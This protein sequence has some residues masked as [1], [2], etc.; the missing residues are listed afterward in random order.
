MKV[1]FTGGSSFTGFWFVKGLAGA[2]HEVVSVF[3]KGDD[4]YS[5]IRKKRMDYLREMSRT[6]FNC[7]FGSDK[8]LSLIRSENWDLLCQ[9]AADVTNYKSPD[10]DIV[11]AVR[12]NTENLSSVLKMLKEKKCNRVLFTGSVF[13]GNEG[14][15]S[16]NLRAFSPYGLSKGLT[17]EIFKY[18]TTAMD[19]RLGKFVIPNPFGPYEEPRFTSYLIRSWFERKIPQVASPAYVRDNIHIS[20]LATAYVHFA[21]N[22]ADKPGFERINPSGYPESQGA[23]ALRFS[24]E[25]RARLSLPCELELAEQRDFPEP[26]VRIN[27]DIISHLFPAWNEKSAWDEL[28]EFYR[29]E[30]EFK[31][32]N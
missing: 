9:H 21:E 26:R 8:F 14:A 12:N 32:G 15:G 6:V 27:T 5:G 25:M 3:T 23:F 20:L 24:D 10:F 4:G 28:A 29:R 2:G 19:M 18:Y 22:L 16:D 13:E 1:L 30:R 11:S 17:C 31:Y 7:A